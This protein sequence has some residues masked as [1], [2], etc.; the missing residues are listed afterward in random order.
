VD[1]GRRPQFGVAV[2]VTEH[3]PLIAVLG[4]RRGWRMGHHDSGGDVAIRGH[5]GFGGGC[6][7]ME[8]NGL[9][10]LGV[11]GSPFWVDAGM[12]SSHG[13]VSGWFVR[14]VSGHCFGSAHP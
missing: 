6:G 5:G 4:T 3:G 8:W 14:L 11:D 12:G 1:W 7:Q 2:V 10:D 13:P 9:R